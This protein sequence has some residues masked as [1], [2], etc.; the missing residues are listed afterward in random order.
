MGQLGDSSK[1][2]RLLPDAEA[3]LGRSQEVEV[4]ATVP[5]REEERVSAETPPEA[6][7]LR[8]AVRE[9]AVELRFYGSVHD[10]SS[11]SDDVRTLESEFSSSKRYDPFRRGR[12]DHDP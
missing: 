11:S 3:E 7:H 5:C 12:D 4:E 8:L 10:A 1:K 6:G 9:L 2:P